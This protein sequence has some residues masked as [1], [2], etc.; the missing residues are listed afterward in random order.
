MN[1]R[2]SYSARNATRYDVT[3]VRSKRSR[4]TTAR[5]ACLKY[6]V[7]VF[8]QRRTGSLCQRIETESLSV[9]FTSSRSEFASLY[10]T[11]STYPLPDVPATA[12]NALNV[13]IRSMS[14]RQTMCLRTRTSR[15]P[16]HQILLS[17]SRA[18]Y[19]IGTRRKSVSASRSQ[20]VCHVS[21]FHRGAIRAISTT[22]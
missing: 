13:I 1:C 3:R 15:H 6:R 11:L 10:L 17:I 8:V 21:L 22:F 5:I 18:P 19:A 9:P 7:P 14:S 4:V 2:R 16:L 20:L 12:S